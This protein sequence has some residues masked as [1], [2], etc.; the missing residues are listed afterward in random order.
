M[1]GHELFSVMT[2]AFIGR[3][4]IIDRGVQVEMRQAKN[5]SAGHGHEL[6]IQASQATAVPQP[7][8]AVAPVE[9]SL[10]V[11]AS[12]PIPDPILDPAAAQ[13]ASA[14]SPASAVIQGSASTAGADVSKEAPS[15]EDAKPGYYFDDPRNL[16][17]VVCALSTHC[18]EDTALPISFETFKGVFSECAVPPEVWPIA[19]LKSF[20]LRG[21]IVRLNPGVTPARYN[22]TD[23]AVAFARGLPPTSTVLTKRMEALKRRQTERPAKPPAPAIDSA[24]IERLKERHDEHQRL[25]ADLAEVRRKLEGLKKSDAIRKEES[26]ARVQIEI[27]ERHILALRKLLVDLSS[28]AKA[29]AVAEDKVKQLERTSNDR[30]LL[31]DLAKLDQLEK[32]PG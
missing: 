30:K 32:H 6:P 16:H 4:Y 1:P 23:E 24:E 13:D 18:G 11:P 10:P 12:P 22:I 26:A 15:G 20:T 5:G 8:T 7:A 19:A 31:A 2:K 14:T 28:Q 9:A 17:L 27:H 29:F 21:F 3:T 25:V